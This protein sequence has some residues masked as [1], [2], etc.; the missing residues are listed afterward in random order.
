MFYLWISLAGVYAK[1]KI[2][3]SFFSFFGASN[4]WFKWSRVKSELST[5]RYWAERP[6]AALSRGEEGTNSSVIEE[7]KFL[8]LH[9]AHMLWIGQ[10]RETERIEQREGTTC[11]NR[12][13]NWIK[14]HKLVLSLMWW[15]AKK[16]N[17]IKDKGEAHGGGLSG[18]LSRY[19]FDFHPRYT[20]VHVHN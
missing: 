19:C 2:Q 7:Q 13:R 6:E 8:P 10:C 12:P 3:C 14:V 20:V 5:E 17:K 15:F 1:I 4:E 11:S 16:Q 18:I 9:F